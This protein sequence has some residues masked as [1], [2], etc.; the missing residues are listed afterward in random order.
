MTDYPCRL[1]ITPPMKC[2]EEALIMFCKKN[3]NPEKLI[4]VKELDPKIHYHLYLELNVSKPTWLARLK[5]TVIGDEG[6]KSFS[7]QYEHSNWDVHRGYLFKFSNTQILYQHPTDALKNPYYIEQHA[8]SFTKNKNF[9]TREHTLML[10]A[11]LEKLPNDPSRSDIGRAVMNFYCENNKPF[12]KANMVQM[13]HLV[14]YQLNPHCQ[15]F[16]NILLE[17]AFPQ[18][19]NEQEEEIQRLNR[20][21]QQYRLHFRKNTKPPQTPTDS[22]AHDSA[23]DTAMCVKTHEQASV[24]VPQT[25][26]LE[27]TN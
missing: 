10:E 9:K 7:N 8:N 16:L 5:K 2:T 25:Q 21:N 11:I 26:S 17:E 14:N 27:S 18:H 22:N 1:R 19:I 12:H 15:T 20:I 13:I 6:N 23:S 24:C 4:I 3:S